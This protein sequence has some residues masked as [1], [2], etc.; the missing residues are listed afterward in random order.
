MV[1]IFFLKHPPTKSHHIIQVIFYI[2][3]NINL[4]VA[5]LNR[6]I[7]DN[8]IGLSKE[9][10]ILDHHA[11]AHILKSSGFRV[12]FMKSGRFHM[13]SSRFHMKCSGFHVKSTY[14]SYK[15]KKNF[16][17]MECCR[18]AMSCF[19]MKSAGFRKTNCQEW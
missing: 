16:S 12:D 19:H 2:L 6:L 8:M 18:K 5:R 15:S 11:K 10:P 13:K 17:F 4:S 7:Y 1:T 14:K 3:I 9:R